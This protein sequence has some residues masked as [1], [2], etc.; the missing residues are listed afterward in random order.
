MNLRQLALG[1]VDT[2]S[3]SRGSDALQLFLLADSIGRDITFAGFGQ[4]VDDAVLEGS[5]GLVCS[6]LSALGKVRKG[7]VE[8]AR[9]RG[10]HGFGLRDGPEFDSSDLFHGGSGANSVNKDLKRVVP[11]ALCN[12]VKRPFKGLHGSHLFAGVGAGSHEFVDVAFIDG[13]LGL[14]EPCVGVAATGV[15]N[16]DGCQIDVRCETRV[17]AGDL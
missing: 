17:S 14:S 3:T 12:L 9:W 8:S 7:D 2:E 10:I 6:L 15:W 11:G 4:F 16:T 1:G 13:E 5:L